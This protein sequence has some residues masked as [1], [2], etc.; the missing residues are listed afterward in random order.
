MHPRAPDVFTDDLHIAYTSR[1]APGQD[2]SVFGP[3]CRTARS[4]NARLG[5]GGVLLFDGQRFFQW[6]Y[7]P[8]PPVRQ[9]MDTI[10]LDPR[11]ADVVVCLDQR[12][13]SQAADAHWRSGFIEPEALDELLGLDALDAVGVLTAIDRLVGRADMEPPVQVERPG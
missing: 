4:R 3:I 10:A 9:L 1:L 5:I 13:G 12:A 2:Y 8:P 6:L 7:G 11:H